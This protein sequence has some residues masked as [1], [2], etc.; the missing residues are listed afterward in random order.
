MTL[1]P[2]APR[3]DPRIAPYRSDLAST[4]LRHVVAAARYVDPWAM[5]IIADVVALRAEPDPGAGLVTQAL[6]GEQ[7]SVYE[8]RDGWAWVQIGTDD[9]IGYLRA[10]A[11]GGPAPE[12]SH[13]VGAL[14]TYLYPKPDLKVPPRGLLSLG[15]RLSVL[16]RKDGFCEIPGGG[17]IASGHVVEMDHAEPDYVAV[18]ERFV[19]TPYLWGGR[20]SIGLDCSALVQLALAATGVAAPRDSDMQLTLGAPLPI[21]DTGGGESP[22]GLRRGDLVFWR[23]HLGIMTGPEMLLHANAHHMAVAEEPLAKAIARIGASG[24]E[25]IGLRR[26]QSDLH[27]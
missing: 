6:F 21:S 10:S 3:P 19:G 22:D 17:Y 7:V 26:L 16:G 23:G 5:E 4:S 8:E 20:S 15:S 2:S 9:Y 12:K 14:R 27:Q 1:A 24:S 25:V 13:K 11:L 18:A